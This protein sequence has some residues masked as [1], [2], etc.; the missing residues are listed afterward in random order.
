MSNL[1]IRV[2]LPLS[3]P[4]VRAN[5]DFKLLNLY[6]RT[7][8]NSIQSNTYYKFMFV[9]LWIY[10]RALVCVLITKCAFILTKFMFMSLFTVLGIFITIYVGFFDLKVFWICCYKEAV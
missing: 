10:E 5:L 1:K 6:F 2:L 3:K 7:F 8:S 9:K 4:M